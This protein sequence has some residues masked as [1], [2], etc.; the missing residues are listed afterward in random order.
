[1]FSEKFKHVSN[2]V[3]LGHPDEVFSEDI[4]VEL[5]EAK[6]VKV[7]EKYYEK[8]MIDFKKH[9]LHLY[10]FDMWKER[11][12][13]QLWYCKKQNTI[14]V[15]RHILSI[16]IEKMSCRHSQVSRTLE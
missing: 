13:S 6:Q 11:N 12:Q 8:Y 5:K 14:S 9:H 4:A 16:Q 2:D 10:H 15:H 3:W 7:D 1:M